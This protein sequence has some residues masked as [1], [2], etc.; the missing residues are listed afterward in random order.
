MKSLI[1]VNRKFMDVSAKELVN[2][3]TSSKYTKGIEFCVSDLNS[4]ELKYL[5]ELVFELGRNNLALQVHSSSLLSIDEQVLFLKKV[6]GYADYLNMPIVI[7][8]HS[9]YD[10]DKELSRVKTHEYF[11]NLICKINNDKLIICL[12]NLNDIPKKDRL[13]KEYIKPVV[14]NNEALY[15]TYD[16]GHE[17]ADYGSITNLDSYMIDDIR[18]VHIHSHDGFGEDH[19][20][21]YKNDKY[22][23]SLLKGIIFLV[24]NKYKYNI[25]FEYNINA[26]R[27]SSLTE[28]IEDYLESIDFVSSHF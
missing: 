18:N 12:E 24:N 14:L 1:S 28:K 21:I 4:D 27:G 20:P 19:L 22:F 26:C 5:D 25:V 7:T 17:L 6:E 8:L 3:I 23:Q 10:D 11:D 2:L 9:I 15:F 16:I 13:E